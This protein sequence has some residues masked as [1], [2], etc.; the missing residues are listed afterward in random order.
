MSKTL[1]VICILF[2]LLTFVLP[3]IAEAQSVGCQGVGKITTISRYPYTLIPMYQV[4]VRVP[5]YNYGNDLFT[6]FKT[7]RR[8]M[9][10]DYVK[11]TGVCGDANQIEKPTVRWQN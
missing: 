5:R 10:G 2:L 11:V 4:T 6:S 8:F 9:I 7:I 3:N 1:A